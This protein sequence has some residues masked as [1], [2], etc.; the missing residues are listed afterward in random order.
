MNAKDLPNYRNSSQEFCWYCTGFLLPQFSDTL[1][2]STP[3]IGD[4]NLTFDGVNLNNT[5]DSLNCFVSTVC[6]YYKLNLKIAYL[7]IN[8]IQNKL[9]KVKNML[10]QNLFDILFIAETK[11][12]GSFTN[13]LLKQPGFRIVRRD[14]KKGAGG[15][16]ALIRDDFQV[17]RRRKLEQE[18]AECHLFGC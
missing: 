8:S 6:D 13:Y 12:D 15:L 17:Y 5:V 2:E 1:F 16:I 18:V 7:D 10:N 3:G 11:I 14:R 4:R 9:D